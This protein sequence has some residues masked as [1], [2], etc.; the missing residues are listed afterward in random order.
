[1]NQNTQLQH[2]I[3]ST[4]G[5]RMPEVEVVLA[6]RPAP[7]R[8]RVVID[9]P[10]GVDLDL[11]ERVTRELGP[12]RERYALEV[13]SPGL[14]RPLVKPDHFR[15]AIGRRV[16]VRTEEPIDGRRRFDGPLVAADDAGVEVEQ[17]GARVRIPYAAVRRSHVVYEPAGGAR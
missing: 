10:E 6:E 7:G 1:M 3:E 15:R 12:V 5:E 11:C 16:A 13:S 17:D 8:V 2:E 4:L 14:D 9:H